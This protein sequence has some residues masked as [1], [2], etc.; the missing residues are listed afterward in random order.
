MSWFTH[1]ESECLFA[2]SKR[3]LRKIIWR[4]MPGYFPGIDKTPG[5]GRQIAE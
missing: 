4:T 3:R 2:P 1:A 5:I